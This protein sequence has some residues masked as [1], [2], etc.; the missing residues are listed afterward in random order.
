MKAKQDSCLLHLFHLLAVLRAD[1]FS[2]QLWLLLMSESLPAL[3][4][5]APE[6]S[7]SDQLPELG[8]KH[9]QGYA[10]ASRGKPEQTG[11]KAGRALPPDKEVWQVLQVCIPYRDLLPKAAPKASLKDLTQLPT[12]HPRESHSSPILLTPPKAQGSFFLLCSPALR[13]A[14]VP[15]EWAPRR[16]AEQQAASGRRAAWL[17]SSELHLSAHRKQAAAQRHH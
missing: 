7:L 8:S 6:R 5:P 17:V 15:G 4:C 1:P 2:Q 11:H 9:C 3:P 13:K 10:S 14:A 16:S 12:P